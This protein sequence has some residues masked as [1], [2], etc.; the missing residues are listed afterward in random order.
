M[1]HPAG[2]MLIILYLRYCHWGQ[3]SLSA[4][5]SLPSLEKSN[6]SL[7]RRSVWS[8]GRQRTFQEA[9]TALV[10]HDTQW[11]SVT[12][13]CTQGTCENGKEEE[14]K[15]KRGKGALLE[16]TGSIVMQTPPVAYRRYTPTVDSFVSST[17]DPLPPIV[18]N[19]FHYNQQRHPKSNTL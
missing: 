16:I 17:S 13:T 7:V 8:Q 14:G 10:C 1:G 5:G 4:G 2:R 18:H 6:G 12:C 9:V 19:N 3:A 11:L 15:R